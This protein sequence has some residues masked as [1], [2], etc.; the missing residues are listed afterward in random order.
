MGIRNLQVGKLINQFILEESQNL[1]FFAFLEIYFKK[2]QWAKPFYNPEAIKIEKG[3]VK[4]K[5]ILFDLLQSKKSFF[6]SKIGIYSKNVFFE[7]NFD[8]T[9]FYSKKNFDFWDVDTYAEFIEIARQIIDDDEYLLTTEFP[10]TEL[11][12]S[13]KKKYF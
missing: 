3:F 5:Q 1:F 4:K 6:S 10:D 12:I 11:T 8:A 13:K 9:D 2:M 7:K